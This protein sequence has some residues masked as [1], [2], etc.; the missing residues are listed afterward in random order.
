[1]LQPLIQFDQ[2]L[3]Y[4]INHG[5]SNVLFDWLM[6]V[7]RI[8]VTWAP[9]YVFIAAFSIYRYKK[10][11]LYLVLTLG[12]TFGVSDFGSASMI[13][14]LV[15][16]VRP[17]NDPALAKTIIRRIP[18]GSGYSFPSSHASNHFAIAIF[19]CMVFGSRWKW[20]WPAALIWAFSISLAQVYVGL[21][22]P[23]DVIGGALYGLTV[24]WIFV[25]LFKKIQPG[26]QL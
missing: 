20:V 1:M 3:F 23:L 11:G 26:F 8:P 4:L 19:L 16:R 15:K 24:G 17:C 13:K 2:H 25:Q 5:L 10:A 12:L 7:I 18:C 9:L 6:P 14:P 22:Y 21:H